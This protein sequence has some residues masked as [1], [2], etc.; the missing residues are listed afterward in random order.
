M[1]PLPASTAITLRMKE[2]DPVQYIYNTITFHPFIIIIINNLS[3]LPAMKCADESLIWIIGAVHL[4]PSRLTRGAKMNSPSPFSCGRR[5]GC[6]TSEN[7][8]SEDNDESRA[9]QAVPP[10]PPAGD[11]SSNRGVNPRNDPTSPPRSGKKRP[12]PP[13]KPRR[14]WAS[15]RSAGLAVPKRSKVRTR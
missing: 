8:L 14:P 6:S 9:A 7:F 1:H 15:T 3:H 10:L 12:K 5:P 13:D 4:A 11:N 2:K